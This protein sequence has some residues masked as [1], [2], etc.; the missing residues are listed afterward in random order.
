MSTMFLATPHARARARAC[1]ISQP[2][3]D[4]IPRLRAF[5]SRSPRSARK[6]DGRGVIMSLPHLY[7]DL[8]GKLMDR[9]LWTQVRTRLAARSRVTNLGVAL[10]T[11]ALA[12]SLLFNMRPAPRAPAPSAPQMLGINCPERYRNVRSVMPVLPGHGKLKLTHLVIVAGHAIWK[13]K[14]SASVDEDSNWF[15]EDYQRGGS[16]NTFVE[17]IMRGY[18]FFAH[19]ASRLQQTI[20]AACLCSAA[21]RR[22]IRRG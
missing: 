2:S 19:S 6:V 20:A 18:V 15:L 10:L 17:H 7:S 9:G 3:A 22:A 11:L 14:E 4:E 8:Q 16:V 12:I 1:S 5:A 13:G 21:A